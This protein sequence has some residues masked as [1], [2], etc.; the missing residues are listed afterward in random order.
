MLSSKVPVTVHTR[1]DLWYGKYNYSL[2][3]RLPEAH[4]LRSLDP[5]KIAQTIESRRRWGR[6]MMDTRGLFPN[7]G[8]WQWKEIEITQEIEDN[9]YAMRDFLANEPQPFY[10]TIFG[11]WMY[12][13]ASDP[14]VLDRVEQL[15]FLDRSTMARGEIQRQGTAGYVQLKDPKHLYRTYFRAVQIEPERAES[16]RNWFTSQQDIRLSPSLKRWVSWQSRWL[17]DY[18]F[19]DHD[20]RTISTMLNMIVPGITRKTLPTEK[21]K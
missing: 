3:V 11:D 8:S 5:K 17:A 1:S 9:V 6:K 18:Y 7:P 4:C 21:A 19:I 16:L 20:S 14:G 13:Y 15:D 12:I 2:R 10:K